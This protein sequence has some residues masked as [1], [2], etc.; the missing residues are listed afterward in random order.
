VAKITMVKCP[1]CTKQNEHLISGSRAFKQFPL[2]KDVFINI[3]LVDVGFCTKSRVIAFKGKVL[4]KTK[5]AQNIF[6]TVMQS[7][8]EDVMH[9]M[10]IR[11]DDSQE[12]FVSKAI[13]PTE[14]RELADHIKEKLFTLYSATHR[15]IHNKRLQEQEKNKKIVKK[16]I[17]KMDEDQAKLFVATQQRV[18]QKVKKNPLY[19]A[20]LIN[21]GVQEA[22]KPIYQLIHKLNGEKTITS[23]KSKT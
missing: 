9:I 17:A 13:N 7:R 10:L 20:S 5:L 1:I 4:V 8:Q 23:I 16:E 15:K 11:A 12:V 3:K 22:L 14:L 6:L 21:E 18:R 2:S 19:I